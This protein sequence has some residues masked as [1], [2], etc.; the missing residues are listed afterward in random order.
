MARMRRLDCKKE[1]YFVCLLSPQV[2]LLVSHAVVAPFPRAFF[3][4][5]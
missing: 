2:H 5:R 3:S 1:A 4:W